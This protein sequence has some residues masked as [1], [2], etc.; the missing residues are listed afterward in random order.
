MQSCLEE[1]SELTCAVV[2][3]CTK[4]NGNYIRRW[5]GDLSPRAEKLLKEY[6]ALNDIDKLSKACM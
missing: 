4:E 3:V 6:A 2:N 5:D 1:F